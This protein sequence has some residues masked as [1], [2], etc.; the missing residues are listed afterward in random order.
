M[1]VL[2][3]QA[4]KMFECEISVLVAPEG[5]SAV[6]RQTGAVSSRLDVRTQ[7]TAMAELRRRSDKTQIEIPEKEIRSRYSSSTREMITKI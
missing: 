6:Y 4:D 7:N 5:S 1:S 3:N 2:S